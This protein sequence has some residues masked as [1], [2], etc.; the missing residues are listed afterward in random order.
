MR[1]IFAKTAAA[2][3][4]LSAVFML[5]GCG[6]G[7]TLTKT[8]NQG[9]PAGSEGVGEYDAV[10][11]Y[12]LEEPND[13]RIAFEADKVQKVSF[14]YRV[15]DGGEYSFRKDVLTVKSSVFEDET[16]G[17]KRLRVFVNNAYTE[18]TVRVVSKV[19]YTPEDF[20]SI[21][22]NLNGV[23][24]LGADV[25]FANGPFYP[26]GKDPNG[27]STHTFEGIFDGM[28]HALKNI[29]IRA[30]DWAVGEDGEGQ[31]P[32]LGNQTAN[33]ANYSN[34]IFMTTGGSAQIVNTDFV[35]ITV[36]GQ[37]LCAAVAGSNGG[38]IKNCRVTCSLS[39][40]GDAEKS[41]GIAGVNG[42]GDAAGRIEN[43]IV[44]YSS[45]GGS[46]GIADWNV[47]TIKNC[48]A[49]VS[50]DY[51]LHMGYDFIDPEDHEK[52]KAV[53]DDFDYDDYM[54]EFMKQDDWETKLLGKWC[55]NFTIPA[56]PGSIDTEHW[57]ELGYPQFYKGGDIINS[58]VVR[59]EFLLDPANFPEE[60]GWDTNIWN[61]TYGAFPT[62]K[63]QQK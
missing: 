42:S 17:D 10:A 46:R 59:K 44:V 8:P 25:D 26:I 45:A 15:L 40:H 48:Y 2:A 54:N 51:V 55:A 47:G 30:H 43:C 22:N 36:D 18:I 9:I 28:G 56:L 13:V 29:T 6:A 39:H 14:K 57:G 16:A 41:A 62:L 50:D 58:D 12:E 27:G 11:Y 32:S 33:S 49:A 19:I 20:N 38:L 52:G 7:G 53:P 1:K 31:G 35:N 4:A 24:V 61:F 21:R 60:D 5:F 37:G 23:F 3:F 34:G 63:L